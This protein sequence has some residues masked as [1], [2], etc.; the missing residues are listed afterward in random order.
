MW[1]DYQFSQRNKAAKKHKVIWV[2]V[3]VCVCGMG[4]GWSK[5]EK[6][7]IRQLRESS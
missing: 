5:F 2:C 7:M 1:H 4:E 6:E 3:C